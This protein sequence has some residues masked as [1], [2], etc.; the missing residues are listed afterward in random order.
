MEERGFVRVSE[1]AIK[2]KPLDL[3][4]RVYLPARFSQPFEALET[5]LL[6]RRGIMFQL[7]IEISFHFGIRFPRYEISSSKQT[8]LNNS[9]LLQHEKTLSLHEQS[10]EK[11]AMKFIVLYC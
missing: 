4:T 11:C 9:I 3:W 1:T 5:L 8:F 10:L 6:K 7:G 2:A